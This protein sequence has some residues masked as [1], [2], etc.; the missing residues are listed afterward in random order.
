MKLVEGKYKFWY[1]KDHIWE[2]T[3]RFVKYCTENDHDPKCLEVLCDII[4][5]YDFFAGRGF[6]YIINAIERLPSKAQPEI[7]MIKKLFPESMYRF[8][9]CFL[10]YS[11]FYKYNYVV[12][13]LLVPL[14]QHDTF[15]FWVDHDHRPTVLDHVAILNMII[16]FLLESKWSDRQPLIQKIVPFMGSSMIRRFYNAD[17]WGRILSIVRESLEYKSNV[18]IELMRHFISSKTTPAMIE[19]IY[20]QLTQFSDEIIYDFVVY[21][22]ALHEQLTVDQINKIFSWLHTVDKE[23]RLFILHKLQSELLRNGELFTIEIYYLYFLRLCQ[24]CKRTKNEQERYSL[25]IIGN[26]LRSKL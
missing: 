20:R 14:I 2:A 7:I 1:N 15:L 6:A 21:S 17:Q 19:N 23:T 22:E 24:I 25:A 26:S 16:P 10:M 11:R 5:G 18:A 4:S 13:E 3:K 8:G 9:L 12:I